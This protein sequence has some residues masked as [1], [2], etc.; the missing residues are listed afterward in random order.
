MSSCIVFL[1]NK[2]R[3]GAKMTWHFE[4][5]EYEML[6]FPKFTIVGSVQTEQRFI[7]FFHSLQCNW[8]L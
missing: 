8:V 1:L 3:F 4:I 2:T 6:K 5:V 7:C